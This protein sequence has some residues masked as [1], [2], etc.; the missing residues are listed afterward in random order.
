MIRLTKCNCT[1]QCWQFTVSSCYWHYDE[2]S[3]THLQ[4]LSLDHM[5]LT[6]VK[7]TGRQKEKKSQCSCL[8]LSTGDCKRLHPCFCEFLFSILISFQQ[9]FYSF[10]QHKTPLLLPCSWRTEPNSG[11]CNSIIIVMHSSICSILP[12]TATIHVQQM[13]L[14]TIAPQHQHTINA[15]LIVWCD[16]I[17]SC[18]G[19]FQ[20]GCTID[21][22]S[23]CLRHQHGF[24]FYL[25]YWSLPLIFNLENHIS[26]PDNFF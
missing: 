3:L 10:Q 8:R 11:T 4:S 26:S 12:Q 15:F 2:V 18:S 5:D 6:E 17:G 20:A 14:G 19:Q 22:R 1:G 9:C 21:D 25:I 13:A 24:C 16:S 7:E 23:R